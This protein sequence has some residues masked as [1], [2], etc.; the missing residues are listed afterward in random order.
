LAYL[1]ACADQASHFD[2]ESGEEGIRNPDQTGREVPDADSGSSEDLEGLDSG[3]TDSVETGDVDTS[4]PLPADD[5]DGDG[6]SDDCEYATDGLDAGD[7]DS[8]DDGLLDGEEDADQ[9]CVLDE[10]E[11]DPTNPD[12]D[13]D[14]LFDG[15]ELD[16][17]TDPLDADTDD[18]TLE[19][20]IELFSSM[21]DPLNPDSDGDGCSDGVEDRNGDGIIGDCPPGEF[22]LDCSN[23]ETDPNDFDS[24]DDG[25]SDCDEVGSLACS[26]TALIDPLMVINEVADYILAIPP[27]VTHG[28]ILFAGVTDTLPTGTF[29][30][31]PEYNIAE[32][33][34]AIIP[35]SGAI[36]LETLSN[37]LLSVSQSIVPTA[38]RRSS[39]RNILTHDGYDAKIELVIEF[40]SSYTPE[41]LRD[42][43][44]EGLS[45]FS[46]SSITLDS[47]A[48]YSGGGELIGVFEV[49]PRSEESLIV[50][51]AI[52]SRF[53]YDNDL[54]NTG[55]RADDFAGGTSLAMADATLVDDCVGY[56]VEK[57]PEVDF[58]WAIDGSSSMTDEVSDIVSFASQFVE[59]LDIQG[60]DYRLGTVGGKC[61]RLGSDSS[62]S[63]E[64]F[65]L[66]EGSDTYC[67]GSSGSAPMLPDRNGH[68]CNFQFTTDPFT[69]ASCVSFVSAHDTS[70]PASEE[71]SLSMGAV[72]IDRALPRTLDAVDKFRP[73]S[74]IVLIVITDEHEQ[75]F[76]DSLS[77]FN[78]TTTVAST[79]TEE[80]QLAD[81]TQ[82]FI[83]FF[84]NPD[85]LATVFGIYWVPGETCSGGTDVA[86]ATHMVVEGTG[87]SAG[88]ICL[89]DITSTLEEIAASSA[90]LASAFR[91]TG[92]PVA[93]TIQVAHAS[94]GEAAAL[95]DRS[96]TDGFD[97]DNAVNRIVFFGDSVPETDDELT[98]SYNRWEGGIIEC[99]SDDD[100]PIKFFCL[101][102]ICM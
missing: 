16:L 83:D 75:S 12:T 33:A 25:I 8:D 62:I 93:L 101:D 9:D 49:L 48:S 72:G 67:T 60:I 50:L 18:D 1:P 79:P 81:S 30:D 94:P 10:G 57:L 22:S 76:E 87:G 39:G 43:L 70:Y 58:I 24:D 59:I 86:F 98:I 89:S 35:P 53:E 5:R 54:I 56:I 63:P 61:E 78:D 42:R 29:I 26:P 36:D 64:A 45:G 52:T 38:G 96:R 15:D 66:L 55:I 19:D 32:F 6:L 14:L 4:P 46:A 88:S 34:L 41:A 21:T 47:S 99:E 40:P 13:G 69:F 100:C 102:G 80:L 91:L 84:A 23:G 65:Q 77:W 31:D 90:G 73:D 44:I 71:Y 2:P 82:K 17:G 20:G 68:L 28:E 37:I 97:F 74:E 51:G 11:T 27:D 92:R 3:T 95:I 85:I 7:P